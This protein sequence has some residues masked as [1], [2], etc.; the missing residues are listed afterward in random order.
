MSGTNPLYPFSSR[1][2]LL[3]FP[4]YPTSD[5]SARLI[6]YTL[7]TQPEFN[8]FTSSNLPWP[9][10]MSCSPPLSALAMVASVLFLKHS[11]HP[12]TYVPAYAW[13]PGPR[14]CFLQVSHGLPLSSFSFPLKSH[15]SGE[16]V[17]WHNLIEPY[18]PPQGLYFMVFSY[19][20][21]SKITLLPHFYLN[22]ST[23]M[24]APPR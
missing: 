8:H 22:S 13:P 20:L 5:L 24:Q 23:R 9:H 1:T 10:F 4:S 15:F 3:L 14:K 17:P 18:W 11:I 12:V 7:K 19:F 6:S 16:A 2:S 21:L